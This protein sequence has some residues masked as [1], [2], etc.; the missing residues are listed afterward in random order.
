ML[1]DIGFH[2]ISDSRALR[3]SMY[4]KV[5][6]SKCTYCEHV[7]TGKCNF[8]CS[9]C[10]PL[11]SNDDPS[12]QEVL[13]II[14]RL[15]KLGC[16]YY[17]ITGGE[18]TLNQNLISIIKYAYMKGMTV[19]MSTNGSADTSYYDE[20]MRSGCMSFAI[21]LDTNKDNERQPMF[22]I[23]VNNIRNIVAKK[24]NVQIGTVFDDKNIKDAT[25]IV[26][27][28][29]SLGVSDIKIGTASQYEQHLVFGSLS[30]FPNPILQ[31]RLSRFKRGR[32]MRGL[33][34]DD[35]PK[36]YLV[37]DDLTIKGNKHYP[38][39]VYLRE[40]GEPIGELDEKVFKRRLEWFE[41]HDSLKDRIC[42]KYCMDFKCDFNNQAKLF[43]DQS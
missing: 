39:A 43:D 2:G 7:I 28:I 24:A 12:F 13:N 4:K 15:S 42:T 17:H 33:V 21:S 41:E 22:D 1:E 30:S 18:P 37:L 8:N 29:S 23:V 11:S 36:C 27:F 6:I 35:S 14:D 34:E 5:P 32:G 40:G 26:R 16:K 38:C 31:Y 10:N 19:R 25:E 3:S 9:Y 20:I